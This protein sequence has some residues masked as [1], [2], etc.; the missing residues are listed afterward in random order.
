MN[1][2]LLKRHLVMKS[3]R[4]T[5]FPSHSKKC[6]IKKKNE[7]IIEWQELM[8]NLSHGTAIKFSS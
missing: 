7:S 8:K 6:L 4:K 2:H 1:S 3:K 5:A